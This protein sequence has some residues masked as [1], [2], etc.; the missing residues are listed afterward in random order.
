MSLKKIEMTA[1]NNVACIDFDGTLFPFRP[2]YEHNDPIQGAVE[3]MWW[4]KSLGYKVVIYTSRL[5][6]SWLSESGESFDKSYRWVEDRL[7]EFNIPYDDITAEKIPAEFYV[8]DRGI[9]FR[10]SW[11]AVKAE[12]QQGRTD[13]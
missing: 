6:P 5:S 7:T 3:A 1:G 4:L 13:N 9:A 11:A 2:L 8:D 10:G 12:I